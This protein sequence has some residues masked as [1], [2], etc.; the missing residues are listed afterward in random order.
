MLGQPDPDPGGDTPGAQSSR[1]ITDLKDQNEHQQVLIAQ[2]KEMLRK[3]QSTVPQEKV[4]EYINT[5]SKAK[6][7][8]SRLKKDDSGSTERSSSS[9]DSRKHEKVN[10]MKQQ[11]EENK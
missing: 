4:E 5:L 6:A 10:L 2:L 1:E 8:K 9:M 3:E 7:K 11:L